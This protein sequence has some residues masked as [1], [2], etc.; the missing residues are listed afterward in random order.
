MADE[1]L[2]RFSVKDD[3]SPVIERVNEKLGKTKEKA[4]GMIPGLEKAGKG[5]R[6]FASQNAVLLSTLT[7]VGVAL[8]S[9]YQEYQKYAGSVRDV[10]LASG[11]TAEESSK[12]LQVLDDFQIGAEDVTAAMKALK[13]NGMV[14][15][16]DTLAKLAEGYQA[17]QDPAQ[18]LKFVYDNLGRSGTKFLN[19]LN[20]SPAAL[21]AQGDE[22]NKNL[23]LTDQQIKQAE[24]ARLAMDAWSDSIQGA[25]VAL[26]GW[27]G[28]M[29]V[30]ND[31]HTKAIE[32]LKSEGVMVG[33]GVENTQAY[34]DALQQLENAELG[35][36]R[37][38]E[39]HGAALDGDVTAMQAAATAADALKISNDDLISSAI[40]Q[41]DANKDFQKSQDDILAQITQLQAKKGELYAWETDKR[42]EIDDQIE[43]LKRKYDE[44]AQ[45]FE[46]AAN[47][48]LVMM[49]LE[50]IAMLDG[51]KGFSDAEAAK[52]LALAE[53]TGVAEASAIRQVIAFD[54]VST[55]MATGKAK[56]EDMN[57]ILS[58][59]SEKGY[60]ID[61]ALNVIAA[62]GNANAF[63]SGSHSTKTQQ[64]QQGGF[65][66]GG[67]STGPTSGHAEMLHGTEAVI[68]LKG[69]SIPVQLQGGGSGVA[70]FLAV[71]PA[72]ADMIARANRSMFE[73]VGR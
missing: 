63:L 44:D 58:L 25:K 52:A 5:L 61:V 27:V 65:A 26:G 32:L 55:A 59:M 6:D 51:E 43:E 64:S 14:P 73:K 36:T 38:A 71:L 12:L 45:A 48:K 2:I 22:I 46:D 39:A 41:T 3:G 67:I 10:A 33:R 68:P 20:Q 16:I 29:I 60:S 53:T 56:A 50:K 8:A 7:A 28:S 70:D 19:V 42:Q 13:N 23:I 1:I 21:R 37:S 31:N 72:L 57:K 69:G 11:T 40:A 34:R 35:A 30:A 18:K 47:R 24:Q 4:E 15:T 9:S 62:M 17:I 66:D 49:T 54:Q